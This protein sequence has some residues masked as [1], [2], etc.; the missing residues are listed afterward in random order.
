MKKFNTLLIFLIIILSY[1]N[2]VYAQKVVYLSE[3]NLIRFKGYLNNEGYDLYPISGRISI[4]GET[5]IVELICLD[6]NRSRVYVEFIKLS[7][8]STEEIKTNPPQEKTFKQKRK[9]QPVKDR[10]YQISF[11][12]GYKIINFSLRDKY[13]YVSD[14]SDA[15]IYI[16]TPSGKEYKADLYIDGSNHNETIFPANFNAPIE[17]LQSGI[18]VIKPLVEGK[19]IGWSVKINIILKEDGNVEI[20]REGTEFIGKDYPNK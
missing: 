5:S 13:A 9:R 14:Y 19:Y 15:V 16:K 18:Y 1:T 2:V 12:G 20:N 3:K 11:A 4:I 7:K 6:N 17:E 8:N 10:E